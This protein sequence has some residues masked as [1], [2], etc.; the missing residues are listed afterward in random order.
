MGEFKVHIR[1]CSPFGSF[2]SSDNLFVD[3]QFDC[4]RTGW[5]SLFAEI[6]CSNTIGIR[7]IHSGGGSRVRGCHHDIVFDIDYTA[8]ENVVDISV[9]ATE[10]YVIVSF[11]NIG[12]N[13]F[14]RCIVIRR[15][16]FVTILRSSCYSFKHSPVHAVGRIVDLKF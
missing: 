16:H 8:T 1:S 14:H 2:D 15:I 6:S 13:K 3:K 12:K 11:R 7:L 10:T 5:F 4:I 9:Q